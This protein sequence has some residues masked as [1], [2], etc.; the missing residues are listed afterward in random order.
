MALAGFSLD[1]LSLMAL[2][3]S[4]GF[5]V[6][7]AI[8]ML[9]NIDRHLEMGK[10]PRQ[11]A[12]DGAR[13]VGFTIVSM[14]LSLAAVFLPVLFMG[15]IM[16]RLFQEF[17]VTIM[18]AILISGLV[19]LTLTPMMCSRFL[20]PAG[21]TQHGRLYGAIE[22]VWDVSLSAYERSLARVDAPQARHPLRLARPSSPARCTCSASCPRGSCRARTPASSTARPRASRA[23]PST[24]WS[25]TSARRRP[26]W[27]RTRTSRRSCPAWPAAAGR[28]RA[29]RGGS[30]S[31]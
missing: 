26:S 27:R 30:S 16:G 9:E 28:R 6:D 2:T 22:R 31:A 14:T 12:E 18:T 11:A 10:A 20:R 13:E 7:D 5:V 15:G 23:C 21:T 4:L 25:P 29:T 19:S 1:N 8:V 24:A 17:A 3:L